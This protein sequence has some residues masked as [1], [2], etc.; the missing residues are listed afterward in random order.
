MYVSS[1]L[2]INERTIAD[3]VGLDDWKELNKVEFNT[4]FYGILGANSKGCKFQKG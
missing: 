3:K 4:K 2:P 1:L